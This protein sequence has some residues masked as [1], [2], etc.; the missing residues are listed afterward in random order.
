MPQIILVSNNSGLKYRWMDRCML[1][2]MWLFVTPWITA[3]Q[4][5]LSMGFSSK[6]TG[7]G[8]PSFSR[9]SSRPRDWTQVS[10]VSCSGEQFSTLSQQG[11]PQIYIYIYIYIYIQICI[12][13][14]ICV[15]T[16]IHLYIIIYTYTY[17]HLYVIATITWHR[18]IKLLLSQYLKILTSC[19]KDKFYWIF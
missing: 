7:M 10:C 19:W 8:C 9:A 15:Y 11:S 14:N 1:S 6:N 18:L 16:Y 5:P 3:S 13:T 2:H 12:Y 4:A 17:I